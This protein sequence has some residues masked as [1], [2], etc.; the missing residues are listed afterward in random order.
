MSRALKSPDVIQKL[1]AQG[2]EPRHTLPAETAKAMQAERD[3]LV[4][5]I[6]ETGF[7]P[8]QG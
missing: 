8:G 4:K 1:D 7:K 5:L 6:R 2:T 3:R